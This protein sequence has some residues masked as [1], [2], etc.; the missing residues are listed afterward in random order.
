MLRQKMFLQ[1][2]KKIIEGFKNKRFPIYHDNED[3]RFEDND[4][5]DIIDNNGLINY[6]KSLID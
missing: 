5:N 1:W 4:E 2:E 3:S 6:E